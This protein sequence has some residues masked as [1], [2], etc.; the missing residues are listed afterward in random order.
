MVWS[1][2]PDPKP[3]L[4]MI[5]GNNRALL[6]GEWSS[7]GSMFAFGTASHKTFVC[8]WDAN[9][10]WWQ[11]TKITGY[12]S[13]VLSVAFSPNE[14]F[15]ATGSAD[16]S[17]RL[18]GKRISEKKEDKWEPLYEFDAQSW[19]EAVAWSKSGKQIAFAVHDASIIFVNFE[20][21]GDELNVK[22]EICQWNKLPFTTLLF[23]NENELVAG[24]Y[25][26]DPIVFKKGKEW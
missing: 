26:N 14:E 23:L 6:C 13:S 2:N 15:L 25:D 10:N 19:V 12:K 5:Q 1:F 8:S 3:E 18:F 21:V 20:K 4:V 9:N 22:E 24:G 11:G 17:F 16:F 7:S